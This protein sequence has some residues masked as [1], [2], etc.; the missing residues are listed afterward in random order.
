MA[1]FVRDEL[2]VVGQEEMRIKKRSN[3]PVNKLIKRVLR[4]LEARDEINQT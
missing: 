2:W 4:R 1:K 3:I